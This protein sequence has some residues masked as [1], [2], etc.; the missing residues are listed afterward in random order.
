MMTETPS[1]TDP[2]HLAAAVAVLNERGHGGEERLPWVLSLAGDR[3]YDS[4]KGGWGAR[5]ILPLEAIAIAEKLDPVKMAGAGPAARSLAELAQAAMAYVDAA[6]HRSSL[7]LAPPDE[8][9]AARAE[10]ISARDRLVALCS[11]ANQG[12]SSVPARGGSV[13]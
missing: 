11:T 10:A 4:Y 3:V 8:W 13:K 5:W 1:H 9:E 12:A 6:E 2:A 7:A